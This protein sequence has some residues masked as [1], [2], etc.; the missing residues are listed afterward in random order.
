MYSYPDFP[1]H[2]YVELTNIC[3]ARCTICATP[4]MKRPR[5]IMDRD[6]FR[7]I[8]E[9][10]GRKQARKLLP[11]LH[12]ESLLVPGVLDYFRDA[13]RLAPDTHVN[14]TTNGSKLTPEISEEL[15]REELIGSLIVS[16][17]GGDKET[18]EAVRLGLD[19]DVVRAN[20]LHFLRRR[21]ELGKQHLKVSI[22]MVTVDENK[23]TRQKLR[24]VWAEADEVRFSVYFNWGG[25]LENEGRTPNKIN[26]CERLYHY[27]TILADGR[28]AMCCFD[29]EAA[30]AV[31]DVRTHSIEEI[32]H[33]E[34]FNEK[35][36]WLYE[37]NFD[38]LPICGQCD[39]V[40]H[41]NWITPL[42]RLRLSMEERFPR[43][44]GAA[45]NMYKWWLNR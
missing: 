13:R 25:E 23:A 2:V 9:E 24:Q 20:V 21:N 16:I 42:L 8:V 40:N 22:A 4:A 7:R 29:S 14:L 10:C 1:D 33:S 32:W 31:G 35:R 34:A 18:F 28:V 43:A 19:Y 45:G 36:R 26:F 41:P 5:A 3:N 6:L 44:V 17:D 11:F 39:Y 37:K 15:L 30:Y 27:I 12:G 38:Q